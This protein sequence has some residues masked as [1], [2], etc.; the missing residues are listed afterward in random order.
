MAKKIHHSKKSDLLKKF[1]RIKGAVV[2]SM[3]SEGSE[4]AI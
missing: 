3:E 2:E 1:R 4:L